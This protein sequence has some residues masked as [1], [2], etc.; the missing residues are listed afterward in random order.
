MDPTRAAE[1]FTMI[2]AGWL[3]SGPD[4][5]I[6]GPT[7]AFLHGLTAMEP[8]PVHIAVPYR[9]KKR[10]RPGL[11]VHN[12]QLLDADRT[13]V[14]GLPVLCIERVVSDLLCTARPQ[15]ALA[16]VDQALA[17]VEEDAAREA[18]RAELLRRVRQRPDIRG[19]RIAERLLQLATGR[20]RSPA[21]SWLLWSIVDLGFPVP[22]VNYWVPTIDGQPLYELDQCWPKLRIAVEY[23]G[24]AAHAER[25]DRDDARTRDL[26][27][28]GWIVVIV[29][30]EDLANTSRMERELADAFRRRGAYPRGRVVGAL[31]ARR[32]RDSR[33]G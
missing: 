14:H 20:A 18:F 25:Q 13:V 6:T 10:T 3:A 31:R 21:E 27:R 32:H 19:T 12:G 22:E 5:V 16:V 33:G 28:R 9:S 15:D 17:A 23:N 1:P 11:V 8:T 24:H 30:A 4:A 26:E 29:R 7:A 2:T